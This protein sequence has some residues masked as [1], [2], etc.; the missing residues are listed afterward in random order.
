MQPNDVELVRVDTKDPAET[1][2]DI[3][4]ESGKY[5]DVVLEA[6][7]GSAIH[8]TG[9]RYKFAFVVRD[10]TACKCEYYDEV[11]GFFGDANWLNFNTQII[12]TIP[13]AAMIPSLNEHIMQVEAVLLTGGVGPTVAPDASFAT[14]PKFIVHEP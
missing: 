1:I 6:E 4:A 11:E 8:G 14:S 7:A 9:G 13:A 3:T 12:R 2:S 10:L 5:F